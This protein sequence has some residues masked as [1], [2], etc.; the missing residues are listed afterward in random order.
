LTLPILRYQV[1]LT[2]VDLLNPAFQRPL[3][4]PVHRM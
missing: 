3:G 2:S 1:P 4:F